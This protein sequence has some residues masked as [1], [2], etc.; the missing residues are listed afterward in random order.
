V[1]EKAFTNRSKNEV[2]LKAHDTGYTPN[3]QKGGSR[4]GHLE[5]GIVMGVKC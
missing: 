5:R 1:S 2:F 4:V 3:L